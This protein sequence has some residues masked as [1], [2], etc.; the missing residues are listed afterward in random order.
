M[1]AWAGILFSF[2]VTLAQADEV[3]C[4]FEVRGLTYLDG[5]CDA[6]FRQGGSFTLTGSE[7]T[8]SPYLVSVK[9]NPNGTATANWN[10]EPGGND[11]DHPLGTLTRSGACW[12][13]EQ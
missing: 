6:Q 12:I 2:W 13:G 3:D 5:L 1:R 9:R 4:L 11:A 10:G 7:E 8:S